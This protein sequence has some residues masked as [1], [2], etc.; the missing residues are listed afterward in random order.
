MRQ[1]LFF[2]LPLVAAMVFVIMA[3]LGLYSSITGSRTPD[4]VPPSVLIGTPAPPIPDHILPEG[5]RQRPVLVNF[6]ASWCLPCRAEIPALDLLKSEVTIIAIAYKDKP[7]DTAQFLEQYGNPYHSVWQDED[8]Q[9]GIRWGI[10]GVPES[11]LLNSDGGIVLRH[12]GPIL[13]S[14]ITEVIRPEL[15]KLK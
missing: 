13:Q 8:G 14:V 6:M 5:L 15:A 2:L 10:Y 3:A 11:F 4:Q 12:A 1:R 9:T 7:E